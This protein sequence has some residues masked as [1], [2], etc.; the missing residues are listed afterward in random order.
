M[1]KK[2]MNKRSN[3]RSNK[4][5]GG[6]IQDIMNAGYSTTDVFKELNAGFAGVQPG[7]SS[8]AT[9]Q[10][11]LIEGGCAS[12]KMTGGKSRKRKTKKRVRFADSRR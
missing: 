3:K 12:C 6:F 7:P 5:K 2:T 11:Y 1:R 4:Q 10:P 9:Y 8:S